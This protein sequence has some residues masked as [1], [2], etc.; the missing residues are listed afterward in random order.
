[1]RYA[2]SDYVGDGDQAVGGRV[3]G[4]DSYQRHLMRLEPDGTLRALE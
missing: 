4:E 1:M 2:Q 3:A